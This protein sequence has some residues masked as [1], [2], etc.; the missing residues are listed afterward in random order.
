MPPVPREVQVDQ[1]GPD[2]L[3]LGLHHL[4]A[5]PNFLEVLYS[6]NLNR[7]RGVAGQDTK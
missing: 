4:Q 5:P 3:A 7:S 1:R 6:E 2:L